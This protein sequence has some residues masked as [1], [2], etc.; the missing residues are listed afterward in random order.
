MS[1]PDHQSDPTQRSDGQNELSNWG[2]QPASSEP[3][4]GNFEL[5]CIVDSCIMA[6][7]D[8]GAVLAAK[9]L[10]QGVRSEIF[11]KE[12][13]VP[14]AVPSALPRAH[15]VLQESPCD[16]E[17]TIAELPRKLAIPPPTPHLPPAPVRVATAAEEVEMSRRNVLRAALDK[18]VKLNVYDIHRNISGLSDLLHRQMGLGIFH[19]GVEVYGM[20]YMF[21]KTRGNVARGGNGGVVYHLPRRHDQH[22][23]KESIWLGRTTLAVNEVK[24]LIQ[25]MASDWLCYDYDLATRNC[26][27]FANELTELLGVG[28]V[29]P[30]LFSASAKLAKLNNAYLRIRSVVEFTGT[31][32][33]SSAQEGGSS[34]SS[35]AG[36]LAA[37]QTS[38]AA[39]AFAASRE[40]SRCPYSA[41]R[42]SNHIDPDLAVVLESRRSL[43]DDG[44]GRV[45]CSV[46]WAPAQVSW[47]DIPLEEPLPKRV[48]LPASSSSGQVPESPPKP[49]L[50]NE[51]IDYIIDE[52]EAEESDSALPKDAADDRVATEDEHCRGVST[53]CGGW[54]LDRASTGL[55]LSLSSQPP[56]SLGMSSLSSQRTSRS[57]STFLECPPISPK[58]SRLEPWDVDHDHLQQ[59]WADVPQEPES[60]EPPPYVGASCAVRNMT[61]L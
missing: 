59:A 4:P 61:Y 35:S 33:N 60:P 37:A 22:H 24:Q 19:V 28:Q 23:F 10:L 48:S 42:R 18:M 36:M 58:G 9:I 3:Q 12:D 43:S 40:F 56:S 16:S 52:I 41:I 7:R 47:G 32:K 17:E 46:D 31:W 53:E 57:G 51:E 21:G 26:V 29:P 11:C 30:C 15:H 6:E 8:A 2:S 38:S 20:E 55:P 45:Q 25:D 14:S 5:D 50:T 44:C 27:H 13:M 49:L 1:E 54:R 34:S 39:T